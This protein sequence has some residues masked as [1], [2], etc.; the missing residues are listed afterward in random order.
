M[1]GIRLSAIVVFSISACSTAWAQAAPSAA[2]C[3]PY[4][5]YSCLDTSLGD[6]VVDRFFNYYRLEWGEDAAPSD[7][8][9]PHSR[10]DGWPAT[11]ETSPPMPY[12]EYPTGALTSI[13][14][15]RP[16]GADSPLMAAIANTG[17][18]KWLADNNT[19]IYGWVDPG[20]NFSTNSNKF[21]NAPIAYTVNPNVGQLDQA[22]LYIDRWPDTVQTDHFDWGFRLSAIYGQNYRYTNAYGIASWQFNHKNNWEGY[23]FPMMYVDL[24]FPKMFEGLE[25]RVGRYI[26][27][28]DIEAQ[29]APNNILYT[30]SLSYGYDNYTNEGVVASWQLTKNVMLQTGLVDGTETPPGTTTRECPISMCSPARTPQGLGQALI[31]FIPT[32]ESRQIP[33][34]NLQA[35]YACVMGATTAAPFSIP[36]WTGSM[37]VSGATTTCNGTASRSITNST[38]IGMW[39]S[40][41]TGC[42]KTTCRT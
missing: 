34:I 41:P 26:S 15:T 28:P 19:Q 38:S 33:A 17:F 23:D 32:H 39:T 3:D 2:A 7:P 36:A 1:R 29:L 12:A 6:G 9:A 21:G 18:G 24:W 4:K 30:H 20:F 27:I 35:F 42:R 16:N 31:R 11:P 40:N 5:D 25:V 10:R 14:V 22:V 8:N 37:A 13:G